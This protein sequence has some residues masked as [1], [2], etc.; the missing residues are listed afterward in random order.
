[1][2]TA[3]KIGDRG[4]GAGCDGPIAKIARDFRISV[5]DKVP[6][7]LVDFKA[8]FEDTARGALTSLDAVI[9]VIDPTVASL[10]LAASMK[11]MVEQIKADVLPATSH[12]ESSDLIFWANKYF[13]EARIEDVWFVINRINGK[14]DQEYLTQRLREKGIEPLGAIYQDPAI[15]LSWLKGVPIH[16]E[17]PFLEIR[18]IL[19]RMESYSRKKQV[20][21]KTNGDS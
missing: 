1:M 20:E 6:V 10:E 21:G 4:P 12:L 17:D 13:V 3:G 19:E 11:Q 9:V 8:G 5:P 7:T 14:D 18:K 2:F 15:A 16:S